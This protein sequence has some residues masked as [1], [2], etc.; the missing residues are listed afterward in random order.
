MIG[1]A[2]ACAEDLIFLMEREEVNRAILGPPTAHPRY[3]TYP[4]ACQGAM[5][6]DIGRMNV[7][8]APEVLTDATDPVTTAVRMVAHPFKRDRIGPWNV[9][10]VVDIMIAVTG[11]F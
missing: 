9:P 10:V 3:K 4:G 8:P 6:V 11:K 7:Q 2:N 1:G 5:R